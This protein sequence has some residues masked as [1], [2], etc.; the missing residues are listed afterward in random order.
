MTTR[1]ASGVCLPGVERTG[2][3]QDYSDLPKHRYVRQKTMLASSDDPA[4]VALPGVHRALTGLV[5]RRLFEQVVVTA[6]SQW[7]PSP[8]ATTDQPNHKM[9]GVEEL[10]AYPLFSISHHPPPTSRR[11]GRLRCPLGT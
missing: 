10:T 6:P 8:T 3:W 4:H 2:G 9:L 5:L 11:L 1:A 7:Q